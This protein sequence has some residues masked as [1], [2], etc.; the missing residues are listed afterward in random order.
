M[1]KVTSGQAYD[2]NWPDLP[3]I[4]KGFFGDSTVSSVNISGIFFRYILKKIVFKK[5]YIYNTN[6]IF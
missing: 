5:I 2:N 3:T 6:Y 1:R 4:I